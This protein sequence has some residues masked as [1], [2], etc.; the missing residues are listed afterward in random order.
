MPKFKTPRVGVKLDMTPMVDIAFL[1]LT[2]FML[3][4]QF[5]P[6]ELP[7]AQVV[8]PSSNSDIKLPESDVM[9][10]SVNKE[11]KIFLSVDQQRLKEKLFA[12]KIQQQW[13]DFDIKIKNQYGDPASMA[14]LV[15]TFP[16]DIKELGDM[17]VTARISNPKL[18]TIIKADKDAEYGPVLDVMDLLQKAN[19][20]RFNL[21]SDL[22]RE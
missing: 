17:L 10:I 20:I 12:A 13:N 14:K 7:E 1:L 21:L 19:I 6:V 2:F 3:T 11:G 5:R 18:R 15:P 8:L 4:T 9:I 16:V 22:E